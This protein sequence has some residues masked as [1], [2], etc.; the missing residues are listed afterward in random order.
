[1]T[2]EPGAG[3]QAFIPEMLPK[4]RHLAEVR[5]AR[6]LS[7]EIEVDGGIGPDTA[8]AAVGAGASVLIAGTAVFGAADGPAA[9]VARLRQAGGAA[10]RRA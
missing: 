5:E 1:M 7:Y 6:G 9:A 3:G 8:A 2:V 4:I 10:A